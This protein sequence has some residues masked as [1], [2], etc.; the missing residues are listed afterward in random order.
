[1][2]VEGRGL[3]MAVPVTAGNA[4]D[5][6]VFEELMQF[7]RVPRSGGGLHKPGRAPSGQGLRIPPD[8]RLP[9]RPGGIKAVIAQPADQQAH[10]RNLIERYFN[11]LKQFRAIATRFDKPASRYR[12]GIL[13]ASLILWLR[14]LSDTA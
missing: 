12:S 2:I 1:M 10:R 9:A 3:P 11:R 7:V 8:P 5:S 6:T 14:E 13:L 4:Y